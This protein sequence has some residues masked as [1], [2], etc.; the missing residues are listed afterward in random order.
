MLGPLSA[1]AA[2][3]LCLASATPPAG[4]V[5]V[6]KTQSGFMLQVDGEPFVIRGAGG[7]A[8]K[9]QLKAA[10][11]NAFR[12]WG[13]GEDTQAQLDEAHRLGLKVILG[14]WLGHERHGFDYGDPPQVRRQFLQAR[15]AVKRFKDHPALL[16]WA[17]GNEME[18]FKEGDDP[19]IWAAVDAIAKMIKALDP[20]HPTIS[21]VA[22][23]GGGR[24]QAL[25]T[26]APHVDIVG[27]NS[28]GGAPSLPQ[29][30]RAAGGRKPYVVTEFGPPGTWE[31]PMNDWGVPVEKTSTEKAAIYGA[32]YDRLKDDPLCLGSIAFTWGAKQEATATWFSMFLPDGTRLGAV[33]ALCTR[34]SGRPPKNRV[35]EIAALKITGPAQVKPSAVIRASLSAK[36]PEGDPLT[37][38]WV[39]YEEMPKFETG[40]DARPAPPTFPESI[41]KPSLQDATVRMPVR[42]GNYRLFAFVRDDHGGGAI[43]NLPLKVLGQAP[44]HLGAA[45]NLPLVVYGDATSGVPFA[46]SGYMGDTI[47]IEMDLKSTTSPRSGPTCLQVDFHRS[48]GWGGVVWQ[49]PANDWGEEPGGYA[50]HGAQRLIFWAKGAKGGEKVKFGYG[51]LKP[52]KEFHDSSGDERE[53]EL[54]SKWARYTFELKGKNLDRIKSGFFWV[55]GGQGTPVRFFLDDIR[56]ER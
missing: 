30:Y 28:Y 40:G 49:N 3:G 8:S 26:R 24:V 41:L 56:Y 38:Q 20:N 19:K 53:I 4:H 50:L 12:T 35:P 11:A 44:R 31:Q 13:I 23:I 34:W 32:V 36:D 39:L 18:G 29:R 22:E 6:S 48:T 54:T 2:V 9:A 25:H 16:A 42:P 52:D 37:V 10:G 1:V 14:I 27:I 51:L 45:T 7:D 47:S 21:V 17:V 43:A 33:D 5:A 46:P 15:S 55:V